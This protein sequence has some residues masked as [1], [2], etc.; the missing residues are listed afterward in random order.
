MIL[1]EES[2][3]VKHAPPRRST[4][5]GTSFTESA[6]VEEAG[7]GVGGGERR[8]E[9]AEYEVTTAASG[10][11]E[12]GSGTGATHPP[13][14][15][16]AT[17]LG[18]YGSRLDAFHDD[19]D[20]LGEVLPPYT[21]RSEHRPVSSRAR[22]QRLFGAFHAGGG[23]SGDHD[24]AYLSDEASDAPLDLDDG[25]RDPT[26]PSRSS[27]RRVHA[28]PIK[29]LFRKAAPHEH[30]RRTVQF[31]LPFVALNAVMALIFVAC[32]LVFPPRPHHPPH[33]GGF[34]PRR[35]L[36]RTDGE[37]WS[38]AA[39]DEADSEAFDRTAWRPPVLHDAQEGGGEAAIARLT[40]GDTAY[41]SIN[42][43]LSIP[44][45]DNTTVDGRSGG[46]RRFLESFVHLSGPY[47]VGDIEVGTYAYDPAEEI[48]A[49]EGWTGP[50]IRVRVQAIY[51]V[52]I[53]A[54]ADA[55]RVDGWQEL[56]R[57]SVCL[58]RRTGEGTINSTRADEP[59]LFSSPQ[60][61]AGPHGPPAR[62]G[63][64][65]GIYVSVAVADL[66]YPT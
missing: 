41:R 63:M 59:A 26:R 52:A 23:G 32:N 10:R 11:S 1:S 53:G 14:F 44:L 9:S 34:P 60:S 35:P 57:T 2:Q 61:R 7:V 29:Y 24:V 50:H 58:M 28:S 36:P 48:N 33:P 30:G 19:E 56:Q 12:R 21:P 25:P 37:A 18:R 42:T 51:R 22:R 45:Y 40:E 47:A 66:A 55:E 6:H 15:P 39:F 27:R 8:C 46:T 64:G 17:S 5:S 3:D 38:C 43:T 54:V 20:A 4:D 13:A 65:L 62:P 49:L 16:A 31:F